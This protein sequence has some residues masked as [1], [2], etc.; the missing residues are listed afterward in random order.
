MTLVEEPNQFATA[1][2][3]LQLANCLRLDLANALP[4][5]LENMTDF[6]QRVAVTVAQAV[7]QLDDLAFTIAERLKDLRDLAAKHFLGSANRRAFS[8]RIGEQ[9]AEVAVFA[10]ADGAIEADRVAAHCQHA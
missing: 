9:V 1:A 6:F 3:L 5:N 8:A 2:R 7:T 4:G 10:V